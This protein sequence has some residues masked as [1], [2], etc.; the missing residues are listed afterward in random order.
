DNERRSDIIDASPAFGDALATGQIGTAHVD[1]LANATTK[2]DE[3]V[4]DDLLGRA[5]DLLDTATSLSPERFARALGELAR[6][7]EREHG[8]DRD[9]QRRKQTF[10]SRRLNPAA[11]MTEGRFAFHPELANK[12]FGTI[13]RHV[14]TTIAAGEARGDT[15]FVERR[16]DRNRLAAESLGELIGT[17]NDTNRTG[18]PAVSS[19]TVADVTVIIDV[20]TLASGELHDHSVCETSDGAPIPAEVAQRLAC[21]GNITSV[22]VNSDGTALAVGRTSRHATP[23]QRRALAQQYRHCA[24]G[25]C[26]TPFHRTEIHHIIPWEQGGKTDLDNLLPVC[27]RHHHLIH[28]L[29]WHIVLHPDRSI[30]ITDHNEHTIT[31]TPPPTRQPHAA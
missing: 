5:D 31:Q 29:H 8:V 23:K 22:V 25:D 21:D 14:T 12:I 6:R 3:A 10:L 17:T 18:T 9:E 19:P 7:L 4:R 15:E 13:D 30:T 20:D 24:I 16:I 26:D 1:A 28:T 27:S 11:G 2:L